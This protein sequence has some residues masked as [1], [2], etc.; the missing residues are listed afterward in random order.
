MFEALAED[1]EDL[2]IPPDGTAIAA[3]VALRDRLEAK[4]TEA[5]GAFDAASLWDL[6]SATSMAAWLRHH[7]G[8]T[9]RDA[10]RTAARA[11]RLRQLPAT[12]AAWRAG[13]VSSGQLD[14]VL[15]AVQPNTVDM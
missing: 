9:S 7:A 15:A 4:I 6:D 5:A 12:A 10:A 2:C 14:A 13:Q 11:R 8:M 3:A 1:I